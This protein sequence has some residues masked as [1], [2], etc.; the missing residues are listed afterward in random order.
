[1]N[2]PEHPWYPCLTVMKFRSKRKTTI[3]LVLHVVGAVLTD[4]I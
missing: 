3:V 2:A 1:M 4:L